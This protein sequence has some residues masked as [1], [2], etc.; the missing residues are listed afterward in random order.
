MQL[1][2]PL[3]MD[4]ADHTASLTMDVLD[5]MYDC[6]TR[7]DQNLHVVPSLATKWSVDSSGTR[8]TVELRKGVRFH[9]GTPFDAQAVVDSYN[10]LLDPDRGLAG[11]SR[12]RGVVKRVTATG[13]D[14]VLFTLTTSYAS[15]L[16][17]LAVTPIV[18]PSA[19]KEGKLSRQAVGTGPYRFV[20]WKTGEYVL[21]ERNEQYWGPRPAVKQ[22]KWIWTSEP[23]LMNMSVLAGAADIVNPL[24]PIFAEALSRNRKVKLIQGSEARVFW[25]ALNTKSKP[26]DDVRV[27]QALNYATDR[28]ALVRTQLRGFGTPA[29][30]PLAPADF[31]YDPQTRGYPYDL[32]R[33]KALLVK[34]GYPNGFSLKIA[35]QEADAQLV[36]ALQGMWANAHVNLQIDQMEHGVFSQ[37]IFGSPQQK[38]QQGIDCVFAS[39]A[40]DDTDPDYQ[41]DPLY[42]SN[43]WSPAGA[44]LGF[45][46]NPHLDVL[47]ESAAGELDPEK[48]KA[49]YR[50]AQQIISDDAPHVL[51]Y[52]ARDIAAQHLGT[53][54]TAVRLLPGGRVE[55]EGSAP[56]GP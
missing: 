39:W 41:L 15:F 7:F 46:S 50:Q 23:V 56:P 14:T 33:A 48:R 10:R 37:A 53:V 47:L 20:E 26:L 51:L 27:R 4:P 12:V 6:L 55:F 52:Y 38:A 32:E 35:V 3:T 22:L 44:N 30:S 5:P 25:V 17:V 18:S 54:P 43:Q 31:A 34:A 9:D 40:S 21:E 42:R 1:E 2:A 19:E 24:P 16:Q 11:A 13:P 36:E 49:L 28:E 8:W 45:Y 29:N